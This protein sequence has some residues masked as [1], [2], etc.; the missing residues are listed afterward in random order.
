MTLVLVALGS[1]VFV[2]VAAAIPGRIAAS[3]PTALVL[4]SE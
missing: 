3:T 1:M 2:N 4:R